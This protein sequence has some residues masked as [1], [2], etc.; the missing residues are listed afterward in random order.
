MNMDMDLDGTDDLLLFDR[1]GN[2][3]LPFLVSKPLPFDIN[4]AGS[5]RAF[6]PIEHWMQAIDYNDDGKKDIFTYTT[7]G[8]KVFRNDSDSKTEIYSNNKSFPAFAAGLNAN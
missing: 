6:P 5:C 2:R 4:S 3:I 1:I 8:I 7:G